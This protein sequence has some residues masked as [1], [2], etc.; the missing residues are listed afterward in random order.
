M[1]QLERI[2][3]CRMACGLLKK[4]PPFLMSAVL[5]LALA[6][7]S[8][9]GGSSDNS[10]NN[11]SATGTPNTGWYNSTSSAFMLNNADQLAGLAVLVNNGNDF[12]GK[13][14]A[15]SNNID[16]SAYAGGQG[17]TP[18]GTITPAGTR[19]PFSGTF[20]GNG[21][22]ISNLTINRTGDYTG[23]FGFVSGGVVQ[24]LGVVNVSING[25]GYWVGGIAGCTYGFANVT[26]CYSTG[27]ISITGYSVGGIVGATEFM[28][29]VTDSYSTC[30][31]IGTRYV[32]GIVG[33]VAS[34]SVGNCYSTDAVSGNRYVG[35]IAG[36]VISSD[37]T[38]TQ[39]WD[40][41][42]TGIVSGGEVV[43]GIAGRVGVYSY[44]TSCYNTGAV[45]GTVA[46]WVGGIAG[47]VSSGEIYNCYSTGNVSGPNQQIGGIAGGVWAYGMV[48]NCYSTGGVSGYNYI[49]GIAGLTVE[50]STI[51]GCAALNLG[52]ASSSGYNTIGRITSYGVG[53][54]GVV[55]NSASLS[56][57]IA[58]SGMTV[59]SSTVSGSA[60]DIN[61]ASTSG[62][63]IRNGTAFANMFDDSSVWT[64]RSSYLP[65]LFDRTVLIPA[66]IN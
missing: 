49:G 4:S 46:N 32:G 65:G 26:N 6:F 11:T 48:A 14:I 38:P 18:I 9:S 30:A 61:G 24:D 60:S 23:L 50:N 62:A 8:C 43:G 13:T 19:R 17:W 44:V 16:L 63:M 5:A 39:V 41:Y 10:G 29:Y 36:Y 64:K 37:G 20:S 56:N 52:V 47:Y 45:S 40:C 57:N 25:N 51:T 7:V 28:S 33:W 21:K 55:D 54:G 12:S 58:W 31:V 35:G 3:T 34:S 53:D 66:Y 1:L 15:L 59:N 22:T 42:S 27:T 2:K